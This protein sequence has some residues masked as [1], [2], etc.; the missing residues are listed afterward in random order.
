[1]E[2]YP[3]SCAQ[4]NL[5]EKGIGGKILRKSDLSRLGAYIVLR[6]IY[7]YLND[8]TEKLVI[9]FRKY[10]RAW[11]KLFIEIFK[12]AKIFEYEDIL[13]LLEKSFFYCQLAQQGKGITSGN[14][15]SVPNYRE[16]LSMKEDAFNDISDLLPRID[17]DK[18]S[19]KESG[20]E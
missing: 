10:D 2:I 15:I 5:G 9:V 7:R 17:I 4:P 18:I 1:M 16:L 19:V 6:R 13:K 11:E 8:K 12:E 20:N 14:V 3:F